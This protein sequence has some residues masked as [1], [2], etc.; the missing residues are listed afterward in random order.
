MMIEQQS[1]VF[2]HLSFSKA[3]III[4]WSVH[5]WLHSL[6]LCGN[7]GRTV[8][9]YSNT[10]THNYKWDTT[11][12]FVIIEILVRFNYYFMLSVDFLYLKKHIIST[13]LSQIQIKQSVKTNLPMKPLVNIFYINKTK[14]PINQLT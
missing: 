5:S 7:F 12:Q 9:N 13:I 6:Y 14:W 2:A 3:E 10:P 1:C 4:W 8:S 11:Y